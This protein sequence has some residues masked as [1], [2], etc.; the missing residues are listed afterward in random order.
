MYDCGSTL[1]NFLYN[2]IEYSNKA[3]TTL[4]PSPSERVRERCCVR[5]RGTL[6]QPQSHRLGEV[7]RTLRPQVVALWMPCRKPDPSIPRGTPTFIYYFGFWV[8]S[9]GFRVSGFGFRVSGLGFWVLASGFWV[10]GFEFC[11]SGFGIWVLGFEFRVSGFGFRVLSFGFRVSGFGFWL[12]ASGFWVLGF[13]FRV[14]GFG[15][16]LR[17]WIVVEICIYFPMETISFKKFYYLCQCF[18]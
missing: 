9:F 14:L 10:L 17:E 15:F 6:C 13:G 1:Y 3:S 16:W 4:V 2:E 5:D 11:V 7:G 12:L 8:L 18:D